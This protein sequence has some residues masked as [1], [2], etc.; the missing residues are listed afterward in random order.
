[1]STAVTLEELRARVRPWV[2]PIQGGAPAGVPAKHDPA[3]EAVAA[4]VARL[5]SPAGE[6]VRWDDVVVGASG[7][8]QHT[9]KD[10]WLAAY[11]GYGLFSTQGLSGAAVGLS[12][13]SELSERYWADLFPELKRLKGRANAVTWLVDRLARMLPAL[14]AAQ[15][16]AA[17][18]ESL[19]QSARKLAEVSRQRFADQAPTF[20][21]LNDA[22]AR[23][24]AGLPQE[25]PPARAPTP[26]APAAMAS[27]PAPS[28]A[29]PAPA[30]VATPTPTRVELPAP[31]SQP[32]VTAEGATDFLRNVGAALL[33]AATTLRRASS[34]DPLAYRL[35][36]MGLWLHLSALPT[37]NAQG[38][39]VLAPLP[40]AL[41]T[42]LETM[43][44]HARWSE[45]LDEAE[46]ALQQHRFALTLHRFTV[47]ALT[48]LGAS[49]A[50]ARHTTVMELGIL[51]RRLPGAETLLASD[52][53][54]LTDEATHAWLRTEVLRSSAPAPAPRAPVALTLP[55]AAPLAMSGSGNTQALEDEAR[56]LADSGQLADAIARLQATV[57]STLT[58]RE[59]FAAR[60]ALARQAANAGLLPLA[61][62]LFE[63]LDAEVSSHSLDAWEPALAAACLEGWLSTHTA[64]QTDVEGAWLSV[65]VRNRYRRL[66]QLDPTAALRVRQ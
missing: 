24:R 65:K 19:A 25:A 31:P 36:R 29:A 11:L 64:T 43:A 48:G 26:E 7:L 27:P 15:V 62:A 45:V 47:E 40:A 46:S 6:P 20:G 18:L 57:A 23:L 28:P 1:M 49:H 39:T 37:A 16:D 10:L 38:N 2:E 12:L 56:A 4:E 52:G 59:R 9:T 53:S 66:S 14:P 42:R 33:G 54:P 60:L 8:L 51:L 55:P 58:G 63:A 32:P 5:E 30:P 50:A 21:T 3:Y 17:S 35:Q 13:L 22:I 44:S 61:R 41:T 34:A